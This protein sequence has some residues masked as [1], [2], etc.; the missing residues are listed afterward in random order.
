MST[1]T[2]T[3]SDNGIA[4]VSITGKIVYGTTFYLKR[5]NHFILPIVD[6]T[7]KVYDAGP[8]KIYGTILMKDISVTHKDDFIEWLTEDVILD[9]NRFTLSAL[10]GINW[11]LGLNTQVTNCRYSGGSDTEGIFE[12]LAPGIYNMSF[13]YMAV[14]T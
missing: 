10:T 14:I 5:L 3:Q 1:V 9:K 13:E 2:F 8:Y 12:H 11:G 4:S 7:E 6:G